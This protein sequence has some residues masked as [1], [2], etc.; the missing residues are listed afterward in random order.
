MITISFFIF[1]RHQS[2]RF[3][4]LHYLWIIFHWYESNYRNRN[5]EL[6][7]TNT[8][9]VEYFLKYSKLTCNCSFYILIDTTISSMK[10]TKNAVSFTLKHIPLSHTGGTIYTFLS[11]MQDMHEEQFDLWSHLHE[12]VIWSPNHSEGRLIIFYF[13]ISWCSLAHYITNQDSIPRKEKWEMMKFDP[14][15]WIC[16][17]FMVGEILNNRYSGKD[18]NKKIVM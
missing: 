16:L 17:V 15:S 3:S 11:F 6:P 10:E 7:L 8:E 13:P 5:N 14:T 18:R 1:G 9:C 2:K 4:E 12:T